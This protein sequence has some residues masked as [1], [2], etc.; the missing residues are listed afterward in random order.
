[1]YDKRTE[2][3][4]EDQF[5]LDVLQSVLEKDEIRRI[6][7]MIKKLLDTYQEML[8]FIPIDF[9]KVL[10]YNKYLK[11]IFIYHLE[12]QNPIHAIFALMLKYPETSNFYNESYSYLFEINRKKTSK[13]KIFELIKCDIEESE[14]NQ[15]ILDEESKKKL[16]EYL[17]RE[18]IERI[19]EKKQIFKIGRLN[20]KEIERLK[21]FS[22]TDFGL[23]LQELKKTL[24]TRSSTEEFWK[25]N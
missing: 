19:D 21:N 8:T 7:I 6:N 22:F 15:I 23:K 17:V 2:S 5:N 18:I 9:N 11:E 10:T 16:T 25:K 1:M 13:T 12:Q 14:I 20:N 3:D 24:T 4:F